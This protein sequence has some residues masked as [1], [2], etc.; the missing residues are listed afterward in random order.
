MNN[1]VGY[2]DTKGLK[3]E[4]HQFI[5]TEER[6]VDKVLYR[7][8][9]AGVKIGVDKNN[10]I[11]VGMADKYYYLDD[12]GQVNFSIELTVENIYETFTYE[13]MATTFSELRLS[14]H[15]TLYSFGDNMFFSTSINNLLNEQYNNI[16]DH[17][18]LISTNHN[19]YNTLNDIE[20]MDT[21]QQKIN[22][23]NLTKLSLSLTG[24][25]LTVLS[26]SLIGINSV[27]LTMLSWGVTGLNWTITAFDMGIE[28]PLAYIPYGFGSYYAYQTYYKVKNYWPLIN[29]C[30][31]Y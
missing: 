9:P 20:R 30:N 23:I 5:Y 15:R 19:I 16:T 3:R 2:V 25:L 21:A 7:T 13:L 8:G 29:N 18:L 10:A 17:T 27:E 22:N 26:S 14:G 31:A 4:D 28:K 6:I 1:P 12:N 11:Y 24:D